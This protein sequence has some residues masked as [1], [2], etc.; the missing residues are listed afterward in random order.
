MRVCLENVSLAFTGD[1]VEKSGFLRDISLNVNAGEIFGIFGPSASGKTSLIYSI[2]GLL[3]IDRGRL[4][5][6]GEDPSRQKDGWKR[7]RKRL[8]VA[9]QFPEDMF[10]KGSIA[11]EFWDV[12]KE[13]GLSREDAEGL[14]HKAMEIA[15]LDATFFWHVHPLRLSQGQL[16][17]LSIA[18]VHAQ[19]RDCMILDEP[20]AGLGC[21]PKKRIITN[22]SE[23]C[24][25]K[26]KICII[27]SHDTSTLLPV[28]DH[29]I[30]LL[31]GRVVISGSRDD[32]LCNPDCIISSGLSLPPLSDLAIR[33]K[34]AGLPICRIWTDTDQ[35]AEDIAEIIKGRPNYSS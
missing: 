17:M 13:K 27:A 11:D 2:C 21:L 16:K 15:G 34:K 25:S 31:D 33:L 9:F 3:K 7:F 6:N 14:A 18:L 20:T 1:G 30:I 29:G 23:L 5:V 4:L 19:D 24:R 28:I 26:D 22:I 32:I 8:A 10:F 35:A 12:L